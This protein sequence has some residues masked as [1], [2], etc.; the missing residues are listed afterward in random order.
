[1]SE[2]HTSFSQLYS[3]P[4]YHPE[5]MAVGVPQT[6]C[7]TCLGP[8]WIS[9]NPKQLKGPALPGVSGHKKTIEPALGIG[10]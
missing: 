10:L 5:M 3:K 6:T 8:A 1:M 7:L 2:G 9:K 4:S